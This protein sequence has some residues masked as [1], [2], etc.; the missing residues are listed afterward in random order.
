MLSAFKPA[1][2]IMGRIRANEWQRSTIYEIPE[3]LDSLPEGAVVWNAGAP[4]TK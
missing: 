3:I 1:H 4:S 2:E